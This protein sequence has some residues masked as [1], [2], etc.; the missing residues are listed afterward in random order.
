MTFG[1]SSWTGLL[2]AL[3]PVALGLLAEEEEEEGVGEDS[4]RVPHGKSRLQ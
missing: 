2:M 4:R 1:I 3:I